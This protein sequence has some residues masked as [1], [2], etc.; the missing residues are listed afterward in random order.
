MQYYYAIV[1]LGHVI[2]DNGPNQEVP[3]QLADL[4]HLK[5]CL[6]DYLGDSAMAKGSVIITALFLWMCLKEGSYV[7]FIIH[8]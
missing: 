1:G 5:E 7:Y 2:G 8:I 6:T 3:A 4:L